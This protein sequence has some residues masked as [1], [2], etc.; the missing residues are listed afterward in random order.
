MRLRDSHVRDRKIDTPMSTS[1]QEVLGGLSA[2]DHVAQVYKDPDFLMAAVGHFVAAGLQKGEGVVLFMRQPHWGRLCERLRAGGVDAAAAA[3]RG[4][5][6]QRDAEATLARIMKGGM[7]DR[8]AFHEIIGE[9]LA[10]A[11]GRQP[12]VRAFGEMV[13]VL[14]QRGHRVG[15]LHIEEL[16]NELIRSR[17]FALFCAYAMDPLSAASYG[18]PL[19]NVCKAHTHL[20]PAENYVELD[21]AVDEA[22]REVLDRRLARMLNTLA[23]ANRPPAGMPA[24]Q[25]TLIWLKENMPRTADRILSLVR[26]RYTAA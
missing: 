6:I 25:A 15:A 10:G 4:E 14:W 3:A 23:V 20:I 19:E 11:R 5:L 7:P 2:G 17:G 1:W 24:G 18:G 21:A 26:A 22:S 8:D 12:E 9:V 13:D 16:W